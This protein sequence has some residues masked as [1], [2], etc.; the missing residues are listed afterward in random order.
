MWRSGIE[1]IYWS[2]RLVLYINI[3]PKKTMMWSYVNLCHLVSDLTRTTWYPAQAQKHSMGFVWWTVFLFC[4]FFVY[5]LFKFSSNIFF[6]NILKLLTVYV[7]NENIFCFCIIYSW[8]VIPQLHIYLLSNITIILKVEFHTKILFYWSLDIISE[9]SLIVQRRIYARNYIFL[10]CVL[11]FHEVK[12]L[13]WLQ[14]KERRDSHLFW[15]NLRFYPW[16]KSAE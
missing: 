13:F 3:P 16:I 15:V 11:Y 7:A 9:T 14:V 6:T 4:I 12:N 8:N 10:K 5:T 2:K 1:T